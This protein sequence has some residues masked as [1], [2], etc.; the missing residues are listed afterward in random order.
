MDNYDYIVKLEQES[1]YL[2]RARRKVK[3]EN[4]WLAAKLAKV[5]AQNQALVAE[6]YSNF[7]RL[8]QLASDL[9]EKYL[10]L[11]CRCKEMENSL[12]TNDS[13]AT[14]CYQDNIIQHQKDDCALDTMATTSSLEEECKRLRDALR[15]AQS[16]FAEEND[17]SRTLASVTADPISLLENQ[18]KHLNDDALTANTKLVNHGEALSIAVQGLRQLLV[19]KDAQAVTAAEDNAA[20][21]AALTASMKKSA[22]T[23]QEK[24]ALAVE[25]KKANDATIL[26]LVEKIQDLKHTLRIKDAEATKTA[27][28]NAEDRLFQATD[29]EQMKHE[30]EDLKAQM[31]MRMY[32]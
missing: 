22:Q 27:D 10:L 28:A 30:L 16:H 9:N 32:A 18:I 20:A 5:E 2:A 25:A 21:N 8:D 15:N 4:S 6:H 13:L 12:Q 19:E 26:A 31:A 14:V 11:F 23:V 29:K 3:E 17:H 24:D 1:C 7:S